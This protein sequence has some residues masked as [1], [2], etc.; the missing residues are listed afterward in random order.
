[1][2]LS[3]ALLV[4]QFRGWFSVAYD[5]AFDQRKDGFFER[6]YLGRSAHIRNKEWWV[7]AEA[8][9][10]ALQMYAH[11]EDLHYYECF[12]KQLDWIDTAQVDW[13]YG[14]WHRIITPTG[15][16]LGNKSDNWKTPYHNGRALIE[17]LSLLRQLE[18][19]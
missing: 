14:D 13:I 7:Q 1:V 4:S 2:N 17:C 19:R 18:A 6:G 8:M 15:K 3:P 9:L 5:K 12:C 16:V 11:T 10:A